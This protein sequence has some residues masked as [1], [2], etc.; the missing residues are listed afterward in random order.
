VRVHTGEASDGIARSHEADAVTMGRDVHFR[1]SRYQPRDTR[2]FGLL[3]HEATHVVAF[4]Q[5]GSAW[6]RATGAGLA[7]EE[8]DALRR[9]GEWSSR[10]SAPPP[11]VPVGR[12]PRYEAGGV[13]SSPANPAARAMTAPVSRATP[14]PRV[15][16]L[17]V[18][19][20]RKDIVHELMGQLRNEFERGG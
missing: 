10:P 8:H 17:D 5:A 2:G 12:L 7:A 6:R 14:A 18:A 20:L 3:L 13:R 15:E 11:A 9:E 16:S 4:L 19:A 1:R